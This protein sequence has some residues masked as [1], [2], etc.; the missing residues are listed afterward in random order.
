ML[1]GSFK[2]K[3]RSRGRKRGPTKEEL[4]LRLKGIISEIPIEKVGNRRRIN[5]QLKQVSSIKVMDRT[6]ERIE[7]E[8]KTGKLSS[9]DEIIAEMEVECQRILDTI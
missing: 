1:K 2:A 5:E 9:I 6:I 3:P 7:K 4:G 8:K